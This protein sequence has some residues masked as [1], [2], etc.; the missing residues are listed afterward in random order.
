MIMSESEII[1]RDKVTGRFLAG[2]GGGGRKPGSRNRHSE[3]FLAAFADD[4]EQHGADV[5]RKVRAEKPDVYLRIA[6][7]LL[8]REAQ[9]DINVDVLH[10]VGNVLEAFRV[11]NGVLGTNPEHGMKRLRRIAPA[12]GEPDVFKG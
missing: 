2:N 3:N 9:L 10:D 8:P 5:I 12:L 6:A 1:E 11:M 7:D 4:F